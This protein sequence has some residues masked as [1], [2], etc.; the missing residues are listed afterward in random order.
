M[1]SK[2]TYRKYAATTMAAAAAV[3]S[4]APIATAA[5]TNGFPDV[6]TG[7]THYDGIMAMSAANVIEGYGDG[8]FRPDGEIKRAG[9]AKMIQRAL[10]LPTPGDVDA[11][12]SVYTD[13]GNESAEDRNAIA[14]VTAAGIMGGKA[15]GKFD[16]WANVKREQ[17]AQIL[18]R[19]FKL[20]EIETDN[21][22]EVDL[23]KVSPNFRNYVQIMAN[24][25]VTTPVN[26]N[27]DPHNTVKR[28]QFA[29][30]TNRAVNVEAPAVEAKVVSVSA[31]NAKQ[32]QVTF[33]TAMDEDSVTDV[34][35]YAIKR[36]GE[37]A[38][39]MTDN[40]APATDAEAELTEDGK[41]LT[42]TLNNALTAAAWGSIV[43]GDTFNVEYDALKA[44]NGQEIEAGSATVKYSDKVAPEFVSI[45]ASAKE[46]TN[47]VTVTF[48]EPVDTSQATITV[49][50]TLVSAINAGDKPNEI[51]L[52]TASNLEVGKTYNV[53]LLNIKDAAGNLMATNPYTTTVTVASD[54]VAPTVTDIK[55]VRDSL[56]EITFD[57][58][59][60]ASTISNTSIRVLDVNLT[61][62]NGDITQGTVTAK[63]NTG[64]K[65]FLVPIT[66]LP[67]NNGTFS[68]VI[69]VANTIKDAAGNASAAYTKNISITE[70]TT[71]PQVVSTTYNNG[72]TYNGIATPNGAI[73][74]KYNEEVAA[75][76]AHGDYTVV[77]N[78]TG[79]TVATAFS[80]RQV[81]PND[82]TELVLVLSAGVPAD[83]T[84]YTVVAPSSAVTDLSLGA[85]ASASANLSVD[86]SSG[87]PVADDK[88]APVV[89]TVTETAATS[90]SSGTSIA[91]AYTETGSGLDV[92]TVTNVNN[93][94]LDGAA[95]PSGSYITL[96]GTTAT[97]NI[98]AGSFAKD[99]TFALNINGIKDKAGNTMDP[100]VGSV[101]LK[102]D[103][104][105]ELTTATLN[106]N[107]TVTLTFS[108]AVN[109]A[110]GKEADFDVI[111]N[112]SNLQGASL[113]YE[114]ADGI[115]ADAG[116]Y[117][118]TV[119]TKA[120][121]VAD[122][123]VDGTL[124]NVLY[125]DVNGNGSY[126][127]ATDIL[128][129]SKVAEAGT[130]DDYSDGTYD[131]N[132]ATT[133][134]VNSI[135]NPTL[136]KDTSD[137]ENVLKGS[138]SITLK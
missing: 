28:G 5:E 76:A 109:T 6:S 36:A 89:A 108:E 58:A 26:G 131:L 79:A 22:V 60:N 88:T 80:S 83:S 128:V 66:G 129:A 44:A 135:S 118:L 23:S 27:Y 125:I 114:L 20:D 84:T 98:P 57:K 134:K 124:E 100:Y 93:Y 107:G 17:M 62:A 99:K 90:A 113:A 42:I 119:E 130:T 73:V 103:I 115:G 30:F 52:T 63:P 92:A 37:A 54:T 102:D 29:T 59:M 16:P 75:S 61:N 71:A 97:V 18:V 64:N 33:N 85:N 56:L 69:S 13:V 39:S 25:G 87:A 112:G 48:T 53:S 106:S 11:V 136:V 43:E 65:T 121:N 86:V 15:G 21:N 96:A 110:V 10:N 101:G 126:D 123:D 24:L 132:K 127:A 45:S 50:G 7:H 51:V 78:K 2:K 40:S 31:I 91:V 95:L 138:K 117:V 34:T 72:T 111:L 104:A 122:G 32:I 94:R 41:T 70:D 12:L 47:R 35:N 49:D 74:I 19:A 4:V 1:S 105:P 8:T 9:V 81:N 116:K 133:L 77:N 46:T 3:A 120:A 38:L 137:L 14:A 82:A 68:G 55:V 67:F